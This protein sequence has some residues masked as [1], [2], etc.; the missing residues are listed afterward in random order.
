MTLPSHI[1][2]ARRRRLLGMGAICTVLI[3]FMGLDFLTS[4]PDTLS[5]TRSGTPIAATNVASNAARISVRLADDGYEL[6]R[7]G[8]GWHMD[9]RDGYPVR[10]DRIGGFLASLSE[11]S[12][13]EARTQDPRKHDQLGLGDPDNGGSGAEVR[14]Y[15]ETGDTLLSVIIGRRGDTLYARETGDSLAFRIEGELPPLQSR[16][17]WMDFQV[18]A[19]LP[20]AIA[21]VVLTDERGE[22]LH[23]TR[24]PDSGPR[25]FVPA[26]GFEE[27]RLVN[28]LAAATPSLALSRFAPLSVKPLTDLETDPISRHVTLTKDG[29]EVIADAFEE[30]DGP[31]LTIRAVEA[32]EGARRAEAINA[33]AAGWAFKLSRYDWADYTVPI[34][35]IVERPVFGPP[36]E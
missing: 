11:L 28:R 3:G 1:R 18:I 9:R 12:W 32:A 24:P 17:G 5:H 10:D 2:N 36:G 16:Q 25:D 22:T 13:A 23:L 6:I 34:S 31:Y 21:G 15:H 4:Q 29:L 35:D 19:I 20:D 7:G 27:N 30:P 8:T 26:P 33:R 14:V